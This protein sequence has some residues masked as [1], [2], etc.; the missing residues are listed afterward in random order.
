MCGKE[1]AIV[2]K[3]SL[4]VHILRAGSD[5]G[6][7]EFYLEVDDIDQIWENIRDKLDGLTFK[8]PFDREYGMREIHI[9]IPNTKT[10]L[11]VGQTIA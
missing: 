1:Y 7:M 5:I 3:D 6:K 4:T 8:E 9:I 2:R 10:L 11:F